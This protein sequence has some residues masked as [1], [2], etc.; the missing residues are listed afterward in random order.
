MKFNL[1]IEFTTG[2]VLEIRDAMGFE[3]T[4]SGIQFSD[5]IHGVWALPGAALKSV[6]ITFERS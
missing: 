4:V 6:T 1:Q 2:V 5:R 3:S